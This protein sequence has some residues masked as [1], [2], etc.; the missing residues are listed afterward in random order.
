MMPMMMKILI[1]LPTL[2][3]HNDILSVLRHLVHRSELTPV[4]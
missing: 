3:D 1:F 4:L 2:F